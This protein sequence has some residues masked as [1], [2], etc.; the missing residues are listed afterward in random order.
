MACQICGKTCG[1]FKLCKECQQKKNEKEQTEKSI[2]I[3]S[4]NTEEPLSE[5]I[6]CKNESNGYL[7][8]K[9]CYYKYKNKI[10][11]LKITNCTDIE[12]MDESY[13]GKYTCTDGHVVKSKSE[14]TI[15]NY[16]FSK[17]I[18]HA[19]EKSFPID[20][21]PKHD[22][23]PDFFLPEQGIYMEHWGYDDN[24][25][26]YTETKE[27][28]IEQYKK[29]KITLICTNEKDISNIDANLERKLKFFKKDIINF[30][31]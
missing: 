29:A 1:F 18:A 12:L 30:N 28:K 20:N 22:L 17:K 7:F 3:I 13:E 9:D 27:Y 6:I 10:L 14:L 4:V 31:D 5:C 21:D 2:S 26:P 19:Y 15:D 25:K 8:C 24:N 23:H 16:L 11:L